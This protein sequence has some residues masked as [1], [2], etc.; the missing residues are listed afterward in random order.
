MN[1]ITGCYLSLQ[2]KFPTTV[3]Q[4]FLSEPKEGWSRVTHK[5]TSQYKTCKQEYIPIQVLHST[6][7]KFYLRRSYFSIPSEG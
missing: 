7:E 1:Q 4:N 3:Y 2:S 5:S 6:D